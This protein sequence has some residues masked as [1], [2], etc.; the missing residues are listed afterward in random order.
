MISEMASSSLSCVGN[1]ATAFVLYRWWLAAA[2]VGSVGPVVA[3]RCVSPPAPPSPPCG[4]RYRDGGDGGLGLVGLVQDKVG[5]G[6]L[7]A[8]SRDDLGGWALTEAYL[9]HALYR[10]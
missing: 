4:R 3:L 10:Q 6:A 9:V 7:D 2:Q 5:D 1:G 8:L